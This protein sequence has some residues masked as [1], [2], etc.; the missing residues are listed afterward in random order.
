[1]L[2]TVYGM[3]S[4]V[5]VYVCVYIISLTVFV[6]LKYIYLFI[7][8]LAFFFGLGWAPN[9]CNSTFPFFF[10][11]WIV[12]DTWLIW[13][14]DIL[15]YFIYSVMNKLNLSLHTNKNNLAHARLCARIYTYINLNCADTELITPGDYQCDHLTSCPNLDIHTLYHCYLATFIHIYIPKCI[16]NIYIYIFERERERDRE[17]ERERASIFHSKHVWLSSTD[18]LYHPILFL[19]RSSFCLSPLTLGWNEFRIAVRSQLEPS[20]G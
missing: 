20:S 16:I 6:I 3:C 8:I 1:M 2:A 14:Y 5:S 18:N 9:I 17:R 12:C 7:S 10:F 4:C 11:L 19:V 15:K 13:I